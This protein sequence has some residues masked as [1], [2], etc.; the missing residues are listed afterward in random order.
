MK[1]RDYVKL[2]N[3]TL[4]K[5]AGYEVLAQSAVIKA[6][7]NDVADMW[8]KSKQNKSSAIKILSEA[9]K[10]WRKLA[11]LLNWVEPEKFSKIIRTLYPSAWAMWQLSMEEEQG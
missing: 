7:V 10:T 3:E 4:E 8:N 11:T 5:E 9:D 6:F 2:Y 1:A